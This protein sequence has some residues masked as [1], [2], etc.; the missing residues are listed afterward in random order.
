VFAQK[1]FSLIRRLSLYLKERKWQVKKIKW[2]EKNLGKL[3]RGK[4]NRGGKSE[5]DGT[6]S[7]RVARIGE[8]PVCPLVFLVFQNARRTGH[9][10]FCGESMGQPPDEIVC[11]ND[12]K[13]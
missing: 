12:L 11:E 1:L 2:D 10:L 8:R 13:I 6:F 4:E 9:P 3:S 7:V 5:T